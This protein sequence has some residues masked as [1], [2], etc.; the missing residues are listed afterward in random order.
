MIAR[1]IYMKKTIF[2]LFI[3]WSALFFT[4][5]L[6]AAESLDSA[7]HALDFQLPGKTLPA[8]DFELEDLAGNLI[9]LSSMREIGSASCRERV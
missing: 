2:F 6:G 3:L 9:R 5:G 4:T 1:C 7:F 8:I